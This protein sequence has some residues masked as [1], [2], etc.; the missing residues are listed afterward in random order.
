MWLTLFFSTLPH[1]PVMTLQWISDICIFTWVHLY[2]FFGVKMEMASLVCAG[3]YLSLTIFVMEFLKKKKIYSP[4]VWSM[5]KIWHVPTL[6]I[7]T[8]CLQVIS[9]IDRNCVSDSQMN[10]LGKSWLKNDVFICWELRK[11]PSDL[12]DASN[13]SPCY[14]P[15]CGPIWVH[16]VVLA[17]ISPCI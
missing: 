9:H 14:Q 7:T 16:L 1:F 10:F 15:N 11:L 2:K 12:L 13:Y 4:L 6:T 8:K 5:I 17:G 3:E